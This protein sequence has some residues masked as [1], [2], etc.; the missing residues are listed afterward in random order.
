MLAVDEA[1]VGQF[2]TVDGEKTWKLANQE[3]IVPVCNKLSRVFDTASEYFNENG[4]VRTIAEL[5][6]ARPIEPYRAQRIL[7]CARLLDDI[8]LLEAT[9]TSLHEA[10]A[11]VVADPKAGKTVKFEYDQF[12]KLYAKLR[13]EMVK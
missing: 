5:L 6:S 11:E 1:T 2:L 12:N 8:D 7:A 13:S 4:S 9:Q 3:D 10:F